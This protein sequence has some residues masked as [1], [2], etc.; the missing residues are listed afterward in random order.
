LTTVDENGV[1]LVAGYGHGGVE[2]IY[3][4]VWNFRVSVFF[5]KVEGDL[6]DLATWGKHK[7]GSGDSP[8]S[9]DA[10]D[11]VFMLR[12]RPSFEID[13][14]WSVRGAGSRVFVGDGQPTHRIELRIDNRSQPSQPLYLLANSTTIASGCSAN[15]HF[16]H[17]QAALLDDSVRCV[18]G[19]VR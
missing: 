1:L 11:Q 15:V 4:D 16:K 17:P 12:N 2:R 9:F 8:V 3:N 5:P 18:A 14:S 10:P 6:R 7:D 13:E 19:E